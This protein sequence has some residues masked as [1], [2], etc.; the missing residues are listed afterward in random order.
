MFTRSYLFVCGS[1]DISLKFKYLGFFIMKCSF[2]FTYCELFVKLV[3]LHFFRLFVDTM[4]GRKDVVMAFG[5]G[6]FLLLCMLVFLIDVIFY[7]VVVLVVNI[8]HRFC[9]GR[10]IFLVGCFP[11]GIVFFSIFVLICLVLPW[12]DFR[13]C[14]VEEMVGELFGISL[15][16]V[17]YLFW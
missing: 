10:D 11:T 14:L 9:F 12:V 5:T 17:F 13:L 15:V 6:L 1:R 4:L 8:L 2:H 3:S 16:F 7:F